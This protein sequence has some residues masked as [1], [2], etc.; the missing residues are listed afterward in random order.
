MNIFVYKKF[1]I[2]NKSPIIEGPCLTHL[3]FASNKTLTKR[4]VY[5]RSTFFTLK[6]GIS[7]ICGKN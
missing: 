2:G 4:G 1:S 7:I 6:N 5:S 3:V